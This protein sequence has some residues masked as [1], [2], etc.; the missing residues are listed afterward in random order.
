MK[1]KLFLFAALTAVAAFVVS[2]SKDDEG[3]I[4]KAS[5]EQPSDNGKMSFSGRKLLWSADDTISIYDNAS[6]S[7]LYVPASDP[8]SSTCDFKHCSGGV[9]SA[10]PFKA[11]CPA[12]IHTS[13]DE[14][15]LPA[16]QR[17]P[18]GSLTRLPMYAYGTN[19]NLDFYNLCGV[20]R[21]R[22][23]ASSDASVRSIAVTT[24]ANT[25]GAATISGSGTSVTLGTLGGTATTTLSLARRRV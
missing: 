23:S 17:S 3:I 13:A 18:D 25:N 1:R 4:F 7:G 15:T 14:V 11:V 8:N 6:P 24:N 19:E 21:F 12:S 9:A 10:A 5:A 22:L 2:C 20:V 16:V